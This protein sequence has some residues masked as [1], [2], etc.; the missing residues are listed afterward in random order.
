MKFDVPAGKVGIFISGG[1]DS[2]VLY[3]LILKENKNVIPLLMLKNNEQYNRAWA[4]IQYLQKLHNTHSEPVLLRNKDIRPAIRESIGLGFGLMYLGVIKELA[5]FLIDWE[6]NN[7]SDS[8]WVV[9]PFKDL[10]K[11][12]IVQLAIDHDVEH[13]F[14]ITHSCA[15]QA[16]GRCNHCNRC[17]ERSWGFNQLGLTDPGVM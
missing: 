4:V 3:H 7:F 16:F 11:S 13:L 14:L 8:E 15:E 10:D 17:R 9:G 1:L 5:E 2:A 6:P 12:Q